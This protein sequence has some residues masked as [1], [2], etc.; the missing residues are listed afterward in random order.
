MFSRLAI[1]GQ[2][3]IP[4]SNWVW[5]DSLEC[6]ASSHWILDDNISF[7][8]AGTEENPRISINSGAIFRASED[9]VDRYEN[10]ALGWFLI[11]ISLAIRQ[12]KTKKAI[13]SK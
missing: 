13:L 3:S 4:A 8:C 11:T 2:G 10:V 5:E 9:F 12:S 6:G 1:L 7:F